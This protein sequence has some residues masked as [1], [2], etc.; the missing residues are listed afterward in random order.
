MWFTQLFASV[1][2]CLLPDWDGL[3]MIS[4]NTF[5]ALPFFP[6]PPKIPMTSMLDLFLIVPQGPVALS[7]LFLIYFFLCFSL[8]LSV[9]YFFP[10]FSILL[11]R[12][13]IELFLILVIIFF[14]SPIYIL[15]SFISSLS[16]IRHIMSFRRLSLSFC[17]V[18]MKCIHIFSL[19]R[20]IVASL[21]TL[22]NNSITFIISVLASIDSLSQLI[23][24]VIF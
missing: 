22:S 11:F 12:V 8:V 13:Y 24:A 10:F 16:L 9:Y 5:L 2:L 18:C 4:L 14:S 19:K 6:S 23:W 15:S 7:F 20:V 17:F 21:N 3:A 1:G